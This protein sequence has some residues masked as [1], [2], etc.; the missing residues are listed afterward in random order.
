[1]K[2]KTKITKL[3]AFMVVAIT[4]VSVNVQAQTGNTFPSTGQV[5]IGTMTP[6]AKLQVDGQQISIKRATA[7]PA[8]YHLSNGSGLAEWLFGQ[9]DGTTNKFIL[10]KLVTGVETDMFTVSTSGN[11][12]IGTITPFAK[13]DVQGIGGI[14]VTAGLNLD[15]N[16]AGTSA[17]F[18]QFVN[19]GKMIVGWNRNAGAGE[20]DLIS[21]RQSGNTGGFM[22]S[23]LDNSGNVKK[24][25]TIEGTTGNVSMINQLTAD[26]DLITKNSLI[27]GGS[28]SWIFQTPDDGRTSLYVA[29]G[30]N[31]GNWNW[32]TQTEFRNTG[33]VVHNG[34]L[35]VN[36][37]EIS[38]YSGGVART[39]FL[40]DGSGIFTGRL[41]VDGTIL[42]SQIKIAQFNS[43]NWSWPDYVFA[44][45]YQLKPL[46][47][48]EAY[49]NANNHLEGI[50]T[51]EDVRK[52][53][54]DV[55]PVTAKLLEKI[56]EL[57]IYM[58]EMKKQND[59]QQQ[60]IKE[61]Q[62]LVNENH[63]LKK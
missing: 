4:I 48:V 19:S 25:M 5:G 11:V 3:T 55:A 44:K 29:P 42:T 35:T 7:G 21:N 15:P 8:R 16:G 45:E 46:Q 33:E 12:G 40:S 26:G 22:F 9:K 54:F 57:T 28:N 59:V 24:L 49:I 39:Q 31:G 30:S 43:T 10:S 6:T 37:S 17:F 1:M 14:A 47:E 41:K 18:Q 34:N 23:D 51:T 38:I 53:G 13:L 2:M 20:I 36:N 61:L 32:G 52:E 62:Q 27:G 56:E 63:S 50:P 60:Q 58:I